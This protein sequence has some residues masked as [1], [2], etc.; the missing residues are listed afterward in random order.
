L[1]V[2]LD[3]PWL[4]QEGV[5]IAHDTWTIQRDEEIDAALGR[6]AQRGHVAQTNNLIDAVPLDVGEHGAKRDIIAVDVGDQCDPHRVL[7]SRI[8]L[9]GG[10]W[11]I[12]SN[13]AV[14]PKH[15]LVAARDI[16]PQVAAEALA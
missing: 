15:N 12:V 7:C 14:F 11:K 8:R 9:F 6:C 16:G 13:R 4:Q 10:I 2:G 1:C 3:E 5:V